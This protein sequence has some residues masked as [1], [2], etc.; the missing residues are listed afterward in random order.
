M[1]LSSPKAR[2][3]TFFKTRLTQFYLYSSLMTDSICSK[4]R[5]VSLLHILTGFLSNFRLAVFFFILKKDIDV[6]RA[7]ESLFLQHVISKHGCF[8]IS[9]DL[10]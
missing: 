5:N 9:T 4:Y 2:L 6:L 8:L 1:L 10:S 3:L 7:D